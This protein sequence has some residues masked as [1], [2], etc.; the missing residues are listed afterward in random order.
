MF[1]YIRIFEGLTSDSIFDQLFAASLIGGPN[2]KF[3]SIPPLF[4]RYVVCGHSPFFVSYCALQ[5]NN[6]FC[7]SH[8]CKLFFNLAI[9]HNFTY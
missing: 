6:Y 7:F 8:I 5:V 1:E 9:Q 4:S 2:E 3:E